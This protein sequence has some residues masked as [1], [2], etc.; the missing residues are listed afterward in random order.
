MIKVGVIGLGNIATKAY[1]P[2]YLE[3]NGNVEFHYFTRNEDKMDTYKAKYS[4][5][6]TYTNL[7][8]LFALNL[9]A[10]I[11]HTPTHTHGDLILRALNQNFHVFV[12]KPISENYNEVEKLIQLAKE[13]DLILFTGFNRRYAPANVAL[14]SVKDKNMLIVQ[15]NRPN[16][17]QDP[18]FAIFDMMIHMI[19]TSLF[20]LNDDIISSSCKSF[21][22]K[23]GSLDRAIAYFETEDTSCICS[24]NMKAGA[25][26]ETVE[27]MSQHEYHYSENLSKT[28]SIKDAEKTINESN[29]W[30]TTLKQ[31]GFED[32]VADFL[33]KV[34]RKD[35]SPQKHSLLS[36]YYCDQV[37]KSIKK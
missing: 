1:L 26:T 14:K 19:D 13:K 29:D 16:T 2:I 32:M 30:S 21:Q 10:C 18:K 9:D 17:K 37:F 22:N 15:K 6:N 35:T 27:V 3:S 8:R 4:L 33:R 12:D 34:K 5:E 23:D 36:H 20:L 31:R 28:S 24:I 25:R 7:D 11:I